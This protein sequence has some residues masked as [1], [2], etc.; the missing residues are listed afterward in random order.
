MDVTRLRLGVS[1]NKVLE[2]RCHRLVG[3][4]S[5]H[6]DVSTTTTVDESHQCHYWPHPGDIASNCSVF[7]TSAVIIR[8]IEQ[9]LTANGGIS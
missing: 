9:R 7:Q 6:D 3:D 8:A 1:V 5:T 2:E 4:V